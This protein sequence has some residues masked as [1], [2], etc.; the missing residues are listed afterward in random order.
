ME[1]WL[2][3]KWWVSE[4]N[5]HDQVRD[6]LMLPQE[7]RFHDATLRDGEQT[8]GVVFRKEEKIKIAEMLSEIGVH[9]IEAGMPAVSKEDAEAITAIS[10]LNLDSMLMVF[11]RAMKEDIE[12]AVD[13]GVD[14]IILEVPSGYPKLK[15]QFNWTEEELVER[16]IL[17]TNFAKEQGLFVNFFPFDTTRSQLPFLKRFLKNVTANSSPDS[18]SV[19]DTTGSIVP[20]AMRYL[21]REVKNT[22]DLPVEVHTHNDFGLGTAT[23]LAAV[24]EGAE[25]VHGCIN[26]LGERTGNAALEE[27][28][29]CLKTLYGLDI[30]LKFEKF[31][32]VSQE[33]QKMSGKQVAENKAVVG[34][35]PFTREIGLG[36]KVLQNTPL[37][38]FPYLPELVGQDLSI[39]MGKKTG[40]ESV[41]MKLEKAGLS[42][43]AE[44]VQEIV[45]ETK[46]CGIAKK[47]L[48]SDEEFLKLAAEIINS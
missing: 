23:T 37:A 5:F 30:D 31:F 17:A 40:K 46:K 6:S 41:L 35:L 19:I 14:G 3:D 33:I 48:V 16:V 26:G 25:V 38:I 4:Y 8:P 42:A 21:V 20:T 47:G 32:H 9:R 36:M 45:A 13:C 39:V 11:S 43:S 7:V 28:A 2:G 18:V 27:I 44:Q 15:H 34:N 1:K 10:K 29:L 24:E 22:V 12:R